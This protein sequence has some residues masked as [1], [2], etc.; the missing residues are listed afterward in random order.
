MKTKKWKMLFLSLALAVVGAVTFLFAGCGGSGGN[1]TDT[2]YYKVSFNHMS[3]EYMGVD[4]GDELIRTESESLVLYDNNTFIITFASSLIGTI[5]PGAGETHETGFV[6]QEQMYESAVLTGTYEVKSED[7][8][9][10][11]K[12]I[13]LTSFTSL[14]HNNVEQNLEDTTNNDI[15]FTAQAGVEIVINTETT[16]LTEFF[17]FYEGQYVA[18]NTSY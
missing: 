8:L 7:A 3:G 1:V 18:S 10:N 13:A 11:Q 6:Y 9:M 14:W 12:T 4:L 16:L 17:E 2:Y 15:N 5:S